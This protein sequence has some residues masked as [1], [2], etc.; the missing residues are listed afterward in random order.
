MYTL[1]EIADVVH[2][3]VHGSSFQKIN[4]FLTDSRNLNSSQ[5]VLFIA[6][7]SGKNNGH[8]Y[9]AEL[10]KSGVQS[11]LV[12]K[13]SFN[14]T[15]FRNPEIGF[16]VV[17]DTLRALQQLAVFHRSKFNIPV[18]GITGSN[19]KTVVK[20]WL[21]QLLK[22]DYSICRSPKSYNSQIG[23]PLSILNL[24]PTHTLAIF[25]A[26]ISRKGEMQVLEEIIRPTLTLFTAIGSAHDEG[27]KSR[28]EKISEKLLL[29]KN[30][31]QIITNGLKKSEIPESLQSKCICISENNDT[32]VRFSINGNQ[33]EIG[34]NP[35]LQ[36]TFQFTDSA[37]IQN[38]V[39]CV[40]TLRTLLVNDEEIQKRIPWL[41]TV[42]LRLEIKNAIQRS[43]VINDYY[44]SDLDSLKIALAFL[45]QQNR[46]LKKVIVISDI[47]QSGMPDTLLYREI[48]SLLQSA[49]ADTIVGIGKKIGNFRSFL[50]ADSVFY[51]STEEFI[52]N[53]GKISF[54]F[55]DATILLKGARSF[56][57]E[58]ISHLLQLKSHDTVFEINLN[59]LTHNINYYKLLVGE[60][61][62]LMCMVKAMG[63]GG[64]GSELARTLQHQGVQYLAV[65]YADEGVELRQSQIHLPIMV[66]SPE[67]EAYDDI[68]QFNLEPE[69]YSFKTLREFCDTLDRVG[70]ATAFPVHIKIDTGMHRLGF[71]EKDV[72]ALIHFLNEHPQLKVQSV[73]SHLSASDNSNLDDFTNQQINQF[74]QI[75]ERI[76]KGI[77]YTFLRHICNSGAISRFNHAHFDMVRLGIGMHGIGVNKEEQK[78]LE[79]VGT[80][81]TR[82]SQIKTVNAGETVSYNRSGKAEKEIRIATIPIG[83]ADGFHRVYGNG[84]A[85]VYIQGKYCK[86][87]GNICMDMC[88]ID[89]GELNC[90]EGEEVIVFEN[91]N[92]LK[93]LA[94]CANSITYEV[95]TGVS[96][97][98]KRVYVWE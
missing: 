29:A 2:G 41:Q 24:N 61:V 21:Y 50:K 90:N 20:E 54:R 62:K 40:Q 66:M 65:A 35:P 34:G 81:R 25:E 68:I 74:T 67:S 73:F 43:L 4:T 55:S 37:S 11:F 45:Q 9:I 80:L 56:G 71:E 64:G 47:E 32:D 8:Q 28:E 97:R 51:E 86:T 36:F 18:I 31:N 87:I 38:V 95:L 7:Q 44:N 58:K 85:G 77:T 19:G 53:F 15:D 12:Q 6:L 78:K 46:R 83:Y 49:K 42:A 3:N 22:P 89:L 96:A 14:T 79:N 93:A 72:D 59:K 27:F 84:K 13:N 63:Y 17:E 92:Q 5:S 52:E 10:I 82:V 26:G 1:K 16:I 39:T 30:S 57:F 75:C 98:V 23:V 48:A 94:D 76:E 91:F 69:L 88:M 60:K 70:N 33:I